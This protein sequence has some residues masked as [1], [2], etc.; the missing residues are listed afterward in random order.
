[1]HGYKKP[2]FHLYAYNI[3]QNNTV[4]T[5]CTCPKTPINFH[6][7]VGAFVVSRKTFLIKLKFSEN[8]L[9][10]HLFANTLNEGF[11]LRT[12]VS[13]IKGKQMH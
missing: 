5:H 6:F 11:F 7:I 12:K 13:R 3:L 2:A 4:F 1:M 8:R 10:C 9:F